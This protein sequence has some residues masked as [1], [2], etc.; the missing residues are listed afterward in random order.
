MSDN[1]ADA[2]KTMLYYFRMIA[3][4]AGVNWDSD[5]QAEI[6][7]MVDS[8]FDEIEESIDNHNDA[9]VSHVH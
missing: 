8:I 9:L 2:K 6:E 1:R 3:V 5:N 4:K 7:A